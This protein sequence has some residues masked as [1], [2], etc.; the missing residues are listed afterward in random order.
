M[1]EQGRRDDL[2]S[3]GYTLIYLFTQKLPWVS[4]KKHDKKKKWDEISIIKQNTTTDELCKGIPFEFQSYMD[5]VKML[6][7]SDRPD[8]AYCRKIFQILFIKNNYKHDH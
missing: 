6:S 3:I 5:Y 8:Y 4:L 2:E 1:C 7:F